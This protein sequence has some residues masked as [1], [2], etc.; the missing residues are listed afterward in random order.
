MK[1]RAWLVAAALLAGCSRVQ[2]AQRPQDPFVVAFHV[3]RPSVVLLTMRV[4][5]DDPHRK[6]DLEDAYG[7]GVVV[8]S[9]SW[10][11]EILTD[12]H[13]IEDA[14]GLRGLVGDQKRV[15]VRI[16]AR[17]TDDDLALLTTKTPNLQPV[18]LA[19]SSDVE[20]G[21]AI[22]IAGY[23]IPDAFEDEGLGTR[24]SVYAGRVS[25]LRKDA[26]ELDLPV[27]PGESGGPVFDAT[28][29]DLIA[30]AESRFDEERAI[31]F[32]IPIDVV[33]RFLELHARR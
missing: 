24:M 9:G 15:D 7:T 26:L 22:G 19:P 30:I 16:A 6:V 29:G 28:S 18:R 2:S 33:K 21:M 4:P 23:P 27:I 12:E 11:S 3:I 17:D 13:V 10:G 31:G 20:A 8:A 14:R 32:A 25:S 1:I 5:S